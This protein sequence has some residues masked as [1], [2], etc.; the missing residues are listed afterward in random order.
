MMME[1]SNNSA[2]LHQEDGAANNTKKQNTTNTANA[3]DVS[4]QTTNLLGP[5]TV[6]RIFKDAVV[7][8]NQAQHDRENNIRGSND[9]DAAPQQATAMNISKDGR[10]AANRAANI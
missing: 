4:Q 1:D 5:G 2:S 9:G 8:A 7:T 6:E 10:I 3:K